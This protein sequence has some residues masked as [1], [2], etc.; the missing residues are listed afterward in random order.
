MTSGLNLRSSRAACALLV[1]GLLQGCGSDGASDSTTPPPPP[2]SGGVLFELVDLIAQG[3][4][5]KAGNPEFPIQISRTDDGSDVNKGFPW[6]YADE[7]KALDDAIEYAACSPSSGPPKPRSRLDDAMAS[8]TGQHQNGRFR[9]LF[10]SRSGSRQI[11]GDNYRAH[12]CLGR[13]ERRSTTVSPPTLQAARSQ[14]IPYPFADSEGKPNVLQIN[15]VH[16]GT[17]TFG[18]ITMQSPLSTDCERSRGRDHRVRCLLP[19]E[20]A[21][22]IH[23]VE[24]PEYQRRPRQ[25]PQGLR[26]QQPQPR[27]GWQLTTVKPG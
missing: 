25:L 20:R 2:A 26:V 17:S 1:I 23:E 24:S 14:M 15:Y 5:L 10:P 27:L 16:N 3:E 7:L 18:G 21:G 12:Q 8:F 13:R 9:S 4:A 6:V 11:T 22:Q 19:E